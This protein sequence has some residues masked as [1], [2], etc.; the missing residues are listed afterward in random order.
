MRD[1]LETL[2]WAEAEFGSLVTN[3]ACPRRDVLRAVEA[4]FARSIGMVVRVDTDGF[5]E[6]TINGTER[7][8][9]GFVLTEAGRAQ[10][11]EPAP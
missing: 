6:S 10:I 4:G 5:T 11:E 7:H 1:T 2:A 8:A 3:R 9:E